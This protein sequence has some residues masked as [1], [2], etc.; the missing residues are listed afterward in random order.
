MTAKRIGMNN[1]LTYGWLYGFGIGFSITRY[2]ITVELG[3]FYIGL[4]Y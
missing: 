2:Y 1:W 3:F 4:E